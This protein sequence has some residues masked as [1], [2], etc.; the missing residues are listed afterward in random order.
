MLRFHLDMNLER[1]SSLSNDYDRIAFDLIGY[2]ERTGKL[3]E[4]LLGARAMNP[5]NDQLFAFS[6]QFGLAPGTPERPQLEALI[7]SSNSHLD[8]AVWREKLGLLESQVC[9][10]EIDGQHMGTGFLMGPSVVMTNYHVLM[11]VIDGPIE[12]SRVGLRFD[13]K[14]LSTGEVANAGVYYDLAHDW[15]ID[16][17]PYSQIDLMPMPKNGLPADDELDYAL[18]RV[19][20]EPGRAAIGGKEAVIEPGIPTRGWMTPEPNHAFTHNPALF[21]VQ[22]P[23]GQ[24]LKLAL[25]TDAVTDVNDNQTRV[26]YRTNTEPGSSGSPC[27]DQNWN[28][29]ALHHSGDPNSQMPE[30]NEGIPFAPILSLLRARDLD[31]QLGD[32]NDH[33]G[34]QL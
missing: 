23:S 26:Y 11:D 29:V 4:L 15:L 28:L 34:L 12:P 21:I 14:V 18:I 9:S 19:D 31:S 33:F 8:I 2:A 25:D 22:H 6:Q 16:H 1:I 13:F 20:G 27:F 30:W 3:N 32:S 10:I 7:R 17:S 24:P 5:K